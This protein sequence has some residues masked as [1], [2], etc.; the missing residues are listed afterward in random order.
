MNEVCPSGTQS[1]Y[2][3]K[4][5]RPTENRRSWSLL[6]VVKDPDGKKGSKAFSH[7]TLDQINNLASK[8]TLTFDELDKQAVDLRNRLNRELK[9][10]PGSVTFNQENMALLGNYENPLP[11]SY[12][13][14]VY[15]RRKRLVD[16]YSSYCDLRRAVEAVGLVS[17]ITGTER[18]IQAQVDKR[19]YP[20]NKQRRL[21]S[22]LNLLLK[23]IGRLDVQ[24]ERARE[25]Q[26]EVKYLNEDEFNVVLAY[27]E[28][29][30]LKTLCKIA[31]H[32]GLRKGELF[33]VTAGD[34]S[35]SIINVRRQMDDKLKFRPTKTRV[36]RKAF[37]FPE[38]VT[39]FKEW[40]L[41]PVEELHV[42]RVAHVAE[43]FKIACHKAFP[44]NPLKHC[45]FH[46]LRHSYAI[47]L[48]EKG[49][50]L[51]FVA[52]SLGNSEAVC[53]KHY[54]GKV[55]TDGFIE[56]IKSYVAKQ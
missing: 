55:L 41:K 56:G 18:E 42:Y 30:W 4:R 32:S 8:G 37:L 31:F 25:E 22:R 15:G 2:L 27:V 38:G 43:M 23:F 33:G 44:N 19:G 53:E 51:S 45:V 21:I 20:D 24:L 6:L 14:D 54:T 40:V 49:V 16:R 26:V 13:H 48:L 36:I 5:P 52:R 28:Q 29:P 1:Y 10:R 47:R 9:G 11:G 3:L 46:D 12:W 7:P 17:L 50:P 39:D 34:L 35:P